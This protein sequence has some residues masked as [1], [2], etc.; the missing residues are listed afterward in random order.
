MEAIDVKYV[1]D[2]NGKKE[3]VQIPIKDW[4]KLENKIKKYEQIIKLRDELMKAL[5]DV[6]AIQRKKG[7]VEDLKSFLNGIKDY[8][9]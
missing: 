9:Y 3:F 6:S 4:K 1:K 8:S 5:T 2:K 7:K